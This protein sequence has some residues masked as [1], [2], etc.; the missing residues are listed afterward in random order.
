MEPIRLGLI[1]TGL[2]TEKLHWPALARLKDRFQV[3]GFANRTR[4]KAERFS[5]P[6]VTPLA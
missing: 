5:A 1:G 2:A 4:E 6:L 3:V